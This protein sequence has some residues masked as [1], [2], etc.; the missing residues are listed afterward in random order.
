MSLETPPLS[1]YKYLLIR[2][3]PR[4]QEA[5]SK[6]HKNTSEILLQFLKCLRKVDQRQEQA[7]VNGLKIHKSCWN[8]L[9]SC[10]FSLQP[11]LAM[12][13]LIMSQIQ[14]ENMEENREIYSPNFKTSEQQLEVFTFPII[15]RKRKWCWELCSPANPKIHVIQIQKQLQSHLIKLYP[16]CAGSQMLASQEELSQ[17]L[18]PASNSQTEAETLLHIKIFKVFLLTKIAMLEISFVL[19]L[20]QNNFCQVTLYHQYCY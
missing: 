10:S 14:W 15:R 12:K 5:L 8:Q 13:T 3:L 7:H 16:K 1:T 4:T 11:L 9:C 20:P 6:P 18:D 19:F 2:T 17:H